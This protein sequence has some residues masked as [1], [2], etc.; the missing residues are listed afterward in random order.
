MKKT[1]IK[2]LSSTIALTL[3]L[4]STAVGA[5]PAGKIP[6]DEIKAVKAT[7][8]VQE[9]KA[10]EKEVKEDGILAAIEAKVKEEAIAEVKEAEAPAVEIAKTAAAA[11]ITAPVAEAKEEVKAAPEI[12]VVPA[13]EVKAEAPVAEA[14]A[15]VIE[16]E[17]AVE[18]NISAT[19]FDNVAMAFY[20]E[21]VAAA[22]NQVNFDK[23][24]GVVTISGTGAME[25]AVYRHFM[26]TKRFLEATQAAFES[27]YGVE[28]DLVYDKNITDVLELDSDIHYYS[29]ETGEELFVTEEMRMNVNPAD[30]IEYSPR[31]III[32]EG[33]TN[34]SDFAFLFCGDV[35]EVLLPS[36]IETIGE[37]AFKYCTS[38]TRIVIPENSEIKSEAFAYCHSLTDVEL[39]NANSYGELMAESIDGSTSNKALTAEEINILVYGW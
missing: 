38:L 26:S 15:P 24:H 17:A 2:A 8:A 36:T 12:K 7:T 13:E 39:V 25:E 21:P 14:E 33:I 34:I 18:W 10:E 9:V 5:A 31:T 30:F 4:A 16:E 29:R 1:L 3:V 35:E 19:E 27:E 32:D 20:A 22:D 11:E 23:Q 37:G 6:A 28:V